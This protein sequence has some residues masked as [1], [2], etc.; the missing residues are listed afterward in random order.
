MDASAQPEAPQGGER[1]AADR[2]GVIGRARVD[3]ARGD[4]RAF[5]ADRAAKG[6]L[7]SI[8]LRLPGDVGHVIYYNS[9]PRL[10]YTGEV[11]VTLRGV[12]F[13]ALIEGERLG[14]LVRLLKRREC[15]FVQVF[16]PSR[17]HRSDDP[18]APV[19]HRIQVFELFGSVPPG[20]PS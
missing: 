16:E 11:A 12:D 9:M 1:S 2:Y 20:M 10:S 13:Q 8:E 5:S 15:D 17:F 4:Y 6:E 3:D 18:A 14:E 19:V 7:E